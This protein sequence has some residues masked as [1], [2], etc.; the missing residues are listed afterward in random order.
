VLNVILLRNNC[1]WKGGDTDELI[2]NVEGKVRCLT[3]GG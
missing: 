2:Q 3:A 1:P